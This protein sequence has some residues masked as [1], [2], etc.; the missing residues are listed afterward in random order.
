MK[1]N[2]K[3]SP[4]TIEKHAR[5]ELM[6]AQGNGRLFTAKELTEIEDKVYQQLTVKLGFGRHK[7]V[8]ADS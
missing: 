7:K 2:P 5:N 4:I 8:I 3:L 1:R 6:L